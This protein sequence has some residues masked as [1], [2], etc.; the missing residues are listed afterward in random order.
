MLSDI[1]SLF[2]VCYKY[3][4]QNLKQLYTDSLDSNSGTLFCFYDEGTKMVY[5]VGKVKRKDQLL[6]DYFNFY[7]Q[8]DGNIRYYEILP[9]TPYAQ[10]LSTFVTSNPQ[11]GI[12]FMPK[13]YLNHKECEVARLY[14][15]HNKGLIEPVSMTVPRK[16]IIQTTII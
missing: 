2:I 14:K 10:Y 12:G 4:L 8:G 5:L 9:S 3:S 13:R 16:V 11:R 15:L 1:Y 7:F 6:Y